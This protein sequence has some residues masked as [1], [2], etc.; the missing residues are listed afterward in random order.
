MSAAET[1]CKVIDYALGDPNTAEVDVE[2]AFMEL[3]DSILKFM[4]EPR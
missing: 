1:V 4:K 2:Y 3:G